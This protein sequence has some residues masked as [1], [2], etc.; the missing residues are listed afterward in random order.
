[1]SD[2]S[3]P[4]IEWR[5]PQGWG[6]HHPPPPALADMG[7]TAAPLYT[8]RSR[9]IKRE[10]RVCGY[11]CYPLGERWVSLWGGVPCSSAT[12]LLVPWGSHYDAF[13]KVLTPHVP[14]V[15]QLN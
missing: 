3:R 9:A 12:L 4:D 6:R 8:P 13:C 1:M 7:I 2:V 14:Q 10:W 5:V 15:Q 11:L